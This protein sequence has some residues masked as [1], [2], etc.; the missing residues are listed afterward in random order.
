M[1]ILEPETQQTLEKILSDL[2]FPK[3]YTEY[4]WK[5]DTHKKGFPDLCY[6]ET[7]ISDA[8]KTGGIRK[9]HLVDIAKWGKLRNT[10]GISC[11]EPLG[12]VLYVKGRPAPDLLQEPE[13]AIQ[14]IDSLVKGFG[15]TYSSK[16]LHFAVPQV[17]GALDT[18]LVRIFGNAAPEYHL[19]DLD[20]EQSGDRWLIPPGQGGWPKEYGKWITILNY[21]AEQLNKTGKSCPHPLVYYEK[22]LREEGVWLPADVET[23]LFSYA[24]QQLK[25][26]SGS[27]EK[28]IGYTFRDRQILTTATTRRAFL[29]DLQ[30][31]SNECLE[32]LATLGDAV[33]DVVAISRLYKP[34]G[35]S[36][37]ELSQEK[38]DQVKRSRTRAFFDDHNLHE[39][40]RWGNV[41][42]NQRIWENGDEAPDAVTEALIGAIF[43]DAEKRG[44]NGKK[45]IQEF[46]E[47]K[48][49]FE[50][51]SE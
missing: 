43:L 6:L 50:Q 15:P 10:K 34:D 37:G 39:Y 18:R 14:E 38:S 19:L 47:K 22:K 48:K 25:A 11:A 35:K 2:N 33:L 13:T 46:L 23:A 41:E 51:D 30:Y 5:G 27:L 3:L 9:H 49:F 45:I 31:N 44:R 36:E 4:E 7:T 26:S 32:P 12:L 40:I 21:L 8:A 16:L 1:K 29:N 17:F 42:Y 28:I 24:S 20:A